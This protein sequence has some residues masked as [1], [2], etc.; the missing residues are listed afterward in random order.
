MDTVLLRII[1]YMTPTVQLF[2]LYSLM[3]TQ[4]DTI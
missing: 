1:F 4:E 3:T 2:L